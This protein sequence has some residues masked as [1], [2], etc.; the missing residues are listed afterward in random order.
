MEVNEDTKT[1]TFR[2]RRDPY[3]PIAVLKAFVKMGLSL[4]PDNNLPD[5]G[6]ALAWVADPDHKKP[7][8]TTQIVLATFLP[9]PTAGDTISLVVLRRNNDYV[10][11][12]F[13]IFV[14]CYG[15]ELFQVALPSPEKDWALVGS[16]VELPP[17][18]HP[19]DSSSFRYG[20]PYRYPLNLLGN[21][22]VTDE[23]VTITMGYD[24]AINRREADVA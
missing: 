17:F 8:G 24:T 13:T 22:V 12:P 4:V 3:I 1:L 14:L 6:T 9:G 16:Q 11:L 20:R 23:E 5:F 21:A 2:L 10:R 15:N 19:N 18:P 7:V